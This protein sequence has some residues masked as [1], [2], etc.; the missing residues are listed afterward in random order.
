MRTGLRIA[1]VSAAS[2]AAASVPGLGV[3]G[4]NVNGVQEQP[5]I[6][7]LEAIR[8]HEQQ[9]RSLALEQTQNAPLPSETASAVTSEINAALSGLAALKT[10]IAE[11]GPYQDSTL[12]DMAIKELGK[13]EKSDTLARTKVEKNKPAEK[14]V[15]DLDRAEASKARAEL[16]LM[17]IPT[18]PKD[19][20][21]IQGNNVSSTTF[22]QDADIASTRRAVTLTREDVEKARGDALRARGRARR[23]SEERRVGK[24]V[25]PG[26]RR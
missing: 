23:R 11:G 6:T 2:I 22:V 5:R 18:T 21:A 13:A 8:A 10:A 15:H 1:L 26:G 16:F 4:G 25:E 20:T 17:G 19:D 24:S 3:P 7:E 14:V 12:A 9:A